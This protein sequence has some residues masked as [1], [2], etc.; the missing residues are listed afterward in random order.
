MGNFLTPAGKS[1]LIN[2]I[3]H[4]ITA[5]QIAAWD[6]PSSV[7]KNVEKLFANFFWGQVEGRKK[8]H[9]IAWNKC[10]DLIMEGRIAIRS[11]EDIIKAYSVG[12]WWKF[13]TQGSL[14]ARFMKT[15]YCARI[16]PNQAVGKGISC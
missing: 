3:L 5:F 11:L 7:I 12:P 2:H 1:I 15:K 16:H 13:P 8:S 9:R 14:W 10:C 6:P 4:S